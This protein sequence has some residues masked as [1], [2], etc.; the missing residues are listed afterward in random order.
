MEES[1]KNEFRKKQTDYGLLTLDEQGLTGTGVDIGKQWDKEL[2]KMIQAMKATEQRPSTHDSKE[3]AAYS[4]LSELS[5]WFGIRWFDSHFPLYGYMYSKTEEYPRVCYWEGEADAIGWCAK[6]RPEKDDHDVERYVIV[7]WK[8]VDILEFWV[9]KKD[10]YGMYLHQCL[11]YAR[12]LQL[13]LKLH[14][15]PHILIVPINGITG[16]EIHPGRFYDFPEKCKEKIN[17]FEWSTTMPKTQK[18]AK[19]ISVKWPLFKPNVQAQKVDEDTLLTKI[20]KEDAKVSDL[21]EA[22]GWS[23]LELT[24]DEINQE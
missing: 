1:V 23:S 7:D 8:V 11:V 6:L 4:V 2:K 24:T 18:P 21:L 16:K 12:L 5:K 20:F 17:S 19:K 13:H 15:L 10:A 14:Y 22:V 9:K 3:R